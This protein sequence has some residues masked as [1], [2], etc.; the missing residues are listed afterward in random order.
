MALRPILQSIQFDD[1]PALKRRVEGSSSLD[2]IDDDVKAVSVWLAYKAN[3]PTTFDSYR[4][5]GERLLLWC[6][7]EGLTLKKVT[8]ACIARH[9][10]FLENPVPVELWVSSDTRKFPSSSDEWRPFCGQLSNAAL[11]LAYRTIG[12]LFRFLDSVGYCENVVPVRK[13]SPAPR[14]PAQGGLSKEEFQLL[15]DFIESRP[16]DRACDK[17][18][19]YRARF[20]ICMIY[21]CGVSLQELASASMGGVFAMETEPGKRDWWLKVT[22]RGGKHRIVPLSSELI[23]ELR[24]YRLSLGLTD[25]PVPGEVNALVC[26]I[27]GPLNKMSKSGIC[28]AFRSMKMG[29]V[30]YARKVHPDRVASAERV[31]ASLAHALRNSAVRQMVDA[32]IGLEHLIENLGM[33]RGIILA[34]YL[35]SDEARRHRDTIS[36]EVNWDKRTRHILSA[37]PLHEKK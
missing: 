29:I 17:R 1:M 11:E 31:E 9:L 21:V 3:T 10:A 24:V 2:W 12:S 30:E 14:A 23:D 8:K 28:A 35:L 37:V 5:E 26:P 16:R 18:E 34:S 7:Q 25:Y 15:L 32:R 36:R 4:R 6:G 22:G 20:V 27:R 19:Y 33:S 13:F